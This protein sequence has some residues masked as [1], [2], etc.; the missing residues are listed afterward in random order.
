MASCPPWGLLIFRKVAVREK[1]EVLEE[2][3]LSLAVLIPILN[4][5]RLGN[6]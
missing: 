3:D 2:F 1:D 6:A 4:G 5:A